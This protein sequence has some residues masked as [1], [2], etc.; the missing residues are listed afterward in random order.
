MPTQQTDT[1]GIR[2]QMGEEWN[3]AANGWTKWEPSLSNFLWPV[4][5]QIIANVRLA[6]G[7][8][9]LDVGTGTGDL[10]LQAAYHATDQGSVLGIDL[11][12]NMLVTARNRAK[13]LGLK[14]VQFKEAAGDQ[15]AE[16]GAGFDVVLGRFSIMF[17]PDV[18]AGLR[19]LRSLV[20]ADGRV[21]FAVWDSHTVNPAFAIPLAALR[22]FVE[23]PNVDENAPGPLRLAGEGKLLGALEQA[24]FTDIRVEAIELYQFAASI[25][26]YWVML[27]DVS[28]SFRKQ[29]QGLSEADQDKV[30]G[31]VFDA[32]AEWTVDGVVRVPA[33][34]LVATAAPGS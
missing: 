34:A 9:V 3:A 7:M 18:V 13:A 25:E 33:R 17:F 15:F 11:S 1:D 22:P 12:S 10:A 29:L 26:A 31:A 14:Q 4:S 6:P 19:Q 27:S 5:Q 16:R 32:V 20:K 30:K 21:C 24:E 2:N 28:S 23:A 8:C